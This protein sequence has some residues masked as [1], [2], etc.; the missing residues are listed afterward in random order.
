MPAVAASTVTTATEY[1]IDKI[2]NSRFIGWISPCPDRERLLQHLDARRGV[3]PT[4]NHHCWA[5]IGRNDGVV[6]SSDDGEPRGS[7]G[8]RILDVLLGRELREAV[9]VVTRYFGGTKLGVGGLGRAYAQAAREVVERAH[10]G[11]WVVRREVVVELPYEAMVAFDRLLE[12]WA[13]AAGERNYGAAVRIKLAVDEATWDARVH[14]L[15]GVG[16]RVVTST[17]TGR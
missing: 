6:R 12:R 16:A 11:P 10:V 4:A 9:L 7:A 5:W 1:E 3:Y 13:V 8:R 14:E 17:Q 2:L 15:A